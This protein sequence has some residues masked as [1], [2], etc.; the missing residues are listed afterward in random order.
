MTVAAV[1]RCPHCGKEIAA[2]AQHCPHCG[3]VLSAATGSQPASR[4][5]ESPAP[6]AAQPWLQADFLGEDDAPFEPEE[7]DL[8]TPTLDELAAADVP[9]AAGRLVSGVQGLLEPIRTTAT[10]SE[11]EMVAAALVTPPAQDSSQMRVVRLFMAEEQ[12][13]AAPV[14]RLPRRDTPLWLPWIFVTLL[15]AVG[16]AFFMQ[17]ARPS[18]TPRE[19]PGVN[20]AFDA[21]N[22]LPP[23]AAVTVYWAYDPATAGELDLVAAP[24]IQHLLVRGA[25]IEVVSLLPNGPATARRLVTSVNAASDPRNVDAALLP[26]VNY[27][28]LPGG[29]PVLPMLA[30]QPAAL[31]VVLAAQAA[32]VQT[33]LELVAPAQGAAVVAGVGAGADPILRPYLDSGQLAGLV[34]GF[35]GAYSYAQRTRLPQSVA[36]PQQQRSQVVGQNVAGLVLIGLLLAGNVVALLGGRRARD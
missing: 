15:V 18:G 13:L 9:T 14:T 35:D 24:I 30:Q 33:W 34:S 23:Q 22:R 19:W 28:Y 8:R 6:P 11:A 32:D 36:A 7:D 3:A 12:A 5:P 10:V 4:P 31:A 2:D 26:S 17:W 1:M 27:V 21:I 20:A 25:Q 16:A 29:A